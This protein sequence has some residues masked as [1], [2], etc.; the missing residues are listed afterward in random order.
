MMNDKKR[1][2]LMNKIQMYAFAA[3]EC[4]LYLDCHPENRKALAKH[5]EYVKKMKDA[6][7]EYEGLYGPLTAKNAGGNDWNWVKGKWPWQ[8]MEVDR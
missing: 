6:V 8:N 1:E 3:H 5:A 7:A 4:G 2:N